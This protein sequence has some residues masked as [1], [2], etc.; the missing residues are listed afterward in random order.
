MK[1]ILLF[2]LPLLFI[3]S[4]DT[5]DDETSNG[6]VGTWTV[7]SVTYYEN[8][9]CSGEGETD[10][11]INDS[12]TATVTYTEVLA[13]FSL[14]MS[15]TLSN[16]C[17]DAGGT[18]VNDTTCI[19]DGDVELTSTG[20]ATYCD[21]EESGTLDEDN[22]CNFVFTDEWYYTYHED[23][24]GNATYC[25]IYYDQSE[26]FNVETTCGSAVVNDNSAMLQIIGENDDNGLECAI[27]MLSR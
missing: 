10:D 4:C 15:Q 18:M 13:T 19:Y 25:E 27:I 2:V 20:W 22:N 11:F 3:I 17:D 1:K 5:D 26:S 14:N 21:E 6:L 12:L 8:G 7:E 9:N 23:S 24:L 16:Y